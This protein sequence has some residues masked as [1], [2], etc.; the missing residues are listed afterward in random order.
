MMIKFLRNQM[1]KKKCDF[2]ERDRERGLTSEAVAAIGREKRVK[3]RELNNEKDVETWNPRE[4]Q[5]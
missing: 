2:W 1:E 5:K 3:L 4:D